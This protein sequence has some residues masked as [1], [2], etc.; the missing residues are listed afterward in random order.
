MADTEIQVF[1]PFQNNI[2]NNTYELSVEIQNTIF[3]SNA[4]NYSN[5][6]SVIKLNA[7]IDFETFIREEQTS[8]NIFN[9]NYATSAN[10]FAVFNPI[11]FQSVSTKKYA[12]RAR[13]VSDDSFIY[14]R[15]STV[16]SNGNESGFNSNEIYDICILGYN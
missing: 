2:S 6:I 10:Q 16:D 12:M 13:K 11:T 4:F 15:T 14:W 3:Q 7:P 9:V 5:E 8:K 1:K